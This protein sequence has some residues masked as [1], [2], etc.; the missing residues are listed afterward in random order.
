VLPSRR[1]N[2]ELGGARKDLLRSGSDHPG[3]LALCAASF[4]A[5]EIHFP[6]PA[7]HLTGGGQGFPIR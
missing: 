1:R 7:S 2:L 3:W 4:G 6:T 5:P